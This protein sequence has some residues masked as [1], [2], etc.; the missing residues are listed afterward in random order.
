VGV[1]ISIAE[2]LRLPVPDLPFPSV[3]LEVWDFQFTN[4]NPERRAS[5]A[6]CGKG[7]KATGEQMVAK[8]TS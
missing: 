4:P 8:A 5:D 6:N 3:L 1:F 2:I 7:G